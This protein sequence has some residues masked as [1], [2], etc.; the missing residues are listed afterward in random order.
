MA[1]GT[2]DRWVRLI[3]LLAIVLASTT[4]GK[5]VGEVVVRVNDPLGRPFNGWEGWGA[6]M[7]HSR[8]P[9]PGILDRW[10]T[11][12]YT[13]NPPKE[14]IVPLVEARA[15]GG[16]YIAGDHGHVIVFEVVRTE[17]R[18]YGGEH[19][20]IVWVEYNA[21]SGRF[22]IPAMGLWS[23]GNVTIPDLG[24]WTG[25]VDDRYVRQA[26]SVDL[27]GPGGNV[28]YPIG[29]HSGWLTKGDRPGGFD[30]EAFGGTP[31]RF[32]IVRPEWVTA[33]LD[34]VVDHDPGE[35][36]LR[37]SVVGDGAVLCI[38]AVGTLAGFR[39]HRRVFGTG[40]PRPSV[41]EVQPPASGEER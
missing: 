8:T 36:F 9:Q 32:P 29:Q 5:V 17:S 12:V 2:R 24:G 1:V 16:P 27:V 37:N 30:Q 23:V 15:T 19:R 3:A 39:L 38:S 7:E 14:S 40:G 35:V 13:R 33:R 18:S 41:T 4:A 31:P 26:A 28:T 34:A 25:P 20:A 22:D 6:S 11:G 10:D 21:T